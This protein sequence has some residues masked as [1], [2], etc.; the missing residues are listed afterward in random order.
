MVSFERSGIYD[1]QE[2]CDNGT[3][4]HAVVLVGYGTADD[5]DYWIIRNS[6]GTGWAENGYARIKRG[7]NL[8]MTETYAYY[9]T[10]ADGLL[11]QSNEKEEESVSKSVVY[12]SSI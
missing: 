6:W 12:P 1:D 2:S 3:L 9:A 5:T 11:K 10:A 7:V 8:C 4:N